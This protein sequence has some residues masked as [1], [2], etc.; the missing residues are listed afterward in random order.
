MTADSEPPLRVLVV[1]PDLEQAEGLRARLAGSPAAGWAV[2]AATI[3][4]CTPLLAT[5]HADAVLLDLR[6]AGA[7]G[8]E[9]VARLTGAFPALAVVVLTAAAGEEHGVASLRHGAQDYLADDAADPRLLA[10]ALRLAVER[11]PIG[12]R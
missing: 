8:L 9:A 7:S 4:E 10:R 1:A 11:K 6:T 12:E 5:A 2:E 3:D